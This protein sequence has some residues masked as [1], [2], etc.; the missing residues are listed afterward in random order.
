M[1]HESGVENL[2][3]SPEVATIFVFRRRRNIWDCA[4]IYK[5]TGQNY[6]RKLAISPESKI[7]PG[8]S[9]QWL[10]EAT[11][12]FSKSISV[13]Y[14]R[15]CAYGVYMSRHYLVL[16]KSSLLPGA[17]ERIG[18]VWTWGVLGGGEEQKELKTL[19]EF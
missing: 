3:V 18:L 12:V 19:L 17:Y 2:Q 1:V 13:L 16:V 11:G 15:I 4:F 5:G 9:I 7:R 10:T 8:R 14:M 6:S